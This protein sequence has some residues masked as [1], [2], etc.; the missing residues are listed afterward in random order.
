MSEEKKTVVVGNPLDGWMLRALWNYPED[1]RALYRVAD[2]DLRIKCFNCLL[3][4]R[5]RADAVCKVIVVRALDLL[6]EYPPRAATPELLME[7]AG[8]AGEAFNLSLDHADF[9]AFVCGIQRPELRPLLFPTRAPALALQAAKWCLLTERKEHQGL[10]Q[11][12]Q[13]GKLS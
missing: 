13:K 6:L 3:D 10:K 2:P 1:C 4:L 12:K 7:S 11:D 5:L 9:Y 8:E